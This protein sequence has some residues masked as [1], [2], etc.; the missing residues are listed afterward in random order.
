MKFPVIINKTA[1]GYLVEPV[2]PHEDMPVMNEEIYVFSDLEG[3]YKH[4]QQVQEDTESPEDTS[5]VPSLPADDVT[6]F[7]DFPDA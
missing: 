3:L 5:E 6:D 4:L 2:L 1:N 7:E